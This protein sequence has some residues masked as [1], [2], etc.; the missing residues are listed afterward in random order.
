MG[1]SPKVLKKS[2]Q[3]LLNRLEANVLDFEVFNGTG[4]VK[5]DDGVTKVSFN[6]NIR[7]RRDSIIW[8]KAN[9]FGLEVAR[10]LI[11]PDSVF[12]INRYEKSFVAESY[13]KFD[14]LYNVPLSFG[15]LQD[16]ILGNT[17]LD[18]KADM[19]LSFENPNYDISQKKDPYVL[20][21]LIEGANFA[22]VLI[23]VEDVRSG[24]EVNADL[25]DYRS[26][27]ES[28]NFSYFRQYIINKHNVQVANI[29]INY[30]EIDTKDKKKLPFE[31]PSHYTTGE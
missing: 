22:P 15:Q 25:S 11:R 6:A 5:Y 29:Q 26:L 28:K 2:K 16:L 14:S 21:H 3:Q 31:I 13:S 19:L 8:I 10:I 30:A 20:H 17:L 9:F 7:M 1:T 24:Y 27:S 4:K 18:R 23:K 12:A